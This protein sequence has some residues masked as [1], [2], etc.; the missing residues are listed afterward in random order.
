MWMW[1]S[2]PCW[3]TS[4]T[5]VVASLS[6]PISYWSRTV[7]HCEFTNP[8]YLQYISNISLFLSET[9]TRIHTNNTVPKLMYG[10]GDDK[11]VSNDTVAVMEE[12]L[13]EYIVDVVGFFTTLPC[14][15]PVVFVSYFP[16]LTDCYSL[17]SVPNRTH[18][19]T[20]DT[21]AN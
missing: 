11:Q 7:T 16:Y 5:G 9:L 8:F 12:M 18:P 17:R 14:T 1:T 15:S 4:C 21:S 6:E 2:I 13:I 19:D 20:Q 3:P 10:F